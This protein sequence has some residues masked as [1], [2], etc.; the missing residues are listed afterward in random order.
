MADFGVRRIF[1]G[2]RPCSARLQTLRC[3]TSATAGA[4]ESANFCS[5]STRC[6]ARSR[7][8]LPSREHKL[9]TVLV[10]EAPPNADLAGGA[11]V[12]GISRRARAG[13]SPAQADGHGLHRLFVR[14]GRPSARLRADARQLSRTMRRGDASF[15]LLAGRALPEHHSHESRDRLHGRLPHAV[16]RRRDGRSSAHAAAG[17]HS[18]SLH[19]IQDHVHGRGAA[20]PE[21]SAAR[22]AREIRG[23][24]A[25][26]TQNAGRADRRE[27][28]AHARQTAARA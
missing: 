1:R 21:K 4:L 17:I 24:A 9:R 5:S 8:R 13:I 11:A 19:E 3:R 26:E 25:G 12:G 18:R 6:G 10:T 22:P 27:S 15:S 23:A 28:R 2:R 7:K 16:H 20:D 14:H